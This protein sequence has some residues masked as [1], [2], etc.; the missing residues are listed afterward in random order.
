MQA[1]LKPFR[2][3]LSSICLQHGRL[4]DLFMY[5]AFR[6]GIYQEVMLFIVNVNQNK[7]KYK[8][9]INRKIRTSQTR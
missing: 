3:G 9:N 5:L 4:H 8:P 7:G 6:Y 1:Y 2:S